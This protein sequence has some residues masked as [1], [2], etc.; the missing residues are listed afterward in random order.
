VLRGGPLAGRDGKFVLKYFL[1][2]SIS[3][4]TQRDMRTSFFLLSRSWTLR[5]LQDLSPM[6]FRKRRLVISD[7]KR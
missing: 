1:F 7:A 5:R 6:P 3:S 2:A 4:P